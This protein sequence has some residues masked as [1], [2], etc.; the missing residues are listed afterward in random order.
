MNANPEWLILTPPGTQRA[1]GAREP[2]TVA[3]AL[4]EVL[5]ADQAPTRTQWQQR[6]QT[7]DAHLAEW[8]NAGWLQ[9]LSRSLPGPDARLDDFLQH[10]IAALSAERRAVLASDAGFCLGRCGIEPDEA[11][12]LSAAAADFAEFAQRQARR[13]WGGA[14]HAVSFHCDNDFLLPDWSFAPYWV[15]GT[16]YWLIVQGEPLLNN[17]ALVELMWGLKVAGSRFR[18]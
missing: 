14:L 5:V 9:S 1:F 13:G 18:A 15:D 4:Q 17:P 2:D 7:D 11:D 10:V 16:G 8:V 3:L 6:T 12:A